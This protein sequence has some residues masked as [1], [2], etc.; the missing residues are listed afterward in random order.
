[1][2][3]KEAVQRYL[4]QFIESAAYFGHSDGMNLEIIT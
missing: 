1:M 3:D 4:S 2:K